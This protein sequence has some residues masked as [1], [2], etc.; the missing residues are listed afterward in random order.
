M[1]KDATDTKRRVSTRSSLR[2]K[3]GTRAHSHHT[4]EL[5]WQDGE[6]LPKVAPQDTPM[7]RSNVIYFR[8]YMIST[9]STGRSLVTPQFHAVL[10]APYAGFYVL[11]NLN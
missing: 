3:V 9:A 4:E 7:L 6:H 10:L 1:R 2:L 5:T 11:N 8:L